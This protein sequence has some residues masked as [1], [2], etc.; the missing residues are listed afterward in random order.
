MS[1]GPANRGVFLD[2]GTVDNGDLDRSCLER[3]VGEWRWHEHT[4]QDQIIERIRGA[5]VV[6]SNKCVFSREIL[7]Q[8]SDLRLLSLVAT[9]TDNIDLEAAHDRG[10]TVCNIRDYC[11]ESVAQ[12]TITLMLSLLTGLPWYWRQVRAGE[13]SRAMQFC[14][15]DR[16]IREAR[17]LVFGVVGYGSL[18]RAAA[19]RARGLGMEVIVAERRGVAP[20]PGRLSF[21]EVIRRSDV[22]SLHCPLNSETRGLIDRNVLDRMK[23]DAVLIN[24]ARGGIV[25]EEDLANA[26]RAGDIAGA[27]VDTLSREPP[28]A[29]H[30][31]LAEDIPNLLVTPHNAWASRT[32]RQAGLEQVARVIA[33]FLAGEPI[34]RV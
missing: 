2:L 24:T 15:N 6:V 18:G 25:V 23:S 29:D 31:L 26:L 12:H 9:G 32:A 3:V 33:G 19:D 10:V 5:D 22:L 20:R 1:A 8:A 4:G 30:P 27:G 17:G 28:P 7:A 14:L 13:W 34:N 21:D 16:P 11:S